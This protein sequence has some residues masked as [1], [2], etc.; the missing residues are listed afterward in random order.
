MSKIVAAMQIFNGEPFFPYAVKGIAPYVDDLIIV[1]GHQK[2]YKD[3]S[4]DNT[5]NEVWKVVNNEKHCIIHLIAKEWESECE[6]RNAYLEYIRK[7]EMHPDWI[8]ICDSDEFYTKNAMELLVSACNSEKLQKYQFLRYP[9][10]NFYYDFWHYK[11]NATGM[12]KLIRWK[13]DLKYHKQIPQVL[14]NIGDERNLTLWYLAEKDKT[15][16][17]IITGDLDNQTLKCFHYAHLSYNK[18]FLAKEL[19]KL[20]GSNKRDVE[21]PQK[22][23]FKNMTDDQIVMWIRGNYQWLNRPPADCKSYFGV[24]PEGIHEIIERFKDTK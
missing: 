24:H 10:W 6:Q 13:D 22:P 3:I 16:G 18:Y 9:F 11:Q 20:L 4:P 23:K 8:F 21:N 1:Y 17:Q 19:S 12:L 7:E 14:D 5:W 2:E 15:Y